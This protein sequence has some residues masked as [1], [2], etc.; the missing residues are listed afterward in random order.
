VYGSAQL[1]GI[2][3]DAQITN[4]NRTMYYAIAICEQTGTR[5][6]DGA[7][8]VIS[9]KNVYWND[10]RIVF[11]AD[12][13]TAQYAVDRDG[14]VDYSVQDQVQVYCYRN[15]STNPVVPQIY[16]NGSLQPAYNIMPTWTNYYT[17]D[18]LVFAIVRVNYNRE[19]NIT[20]IPQMR[21]Q[22]QNSMTLPG[23]CLYDYMTNTRYGAG[24]DP[25]EIY[26]G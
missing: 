3:F 4:S 2:I 25:T 1:G 21:F 10:G 19:K 11:G 16:S 18:N 13:I 14:N 9:F 22:V 7:A 15:G 8:S 26:S 20:S 5:L 6:S 17:A 23:D 24:I 12:G